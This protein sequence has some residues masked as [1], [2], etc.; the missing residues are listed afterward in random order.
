MRCRQ[1]NMKKPRIVVAVMADTLRDAPG[2]RAEVA[3]R[4]AAS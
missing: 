4:S 2:K 1:E 3:K